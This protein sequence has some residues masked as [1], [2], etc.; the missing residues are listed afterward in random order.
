MWK[1]SGHWEERGNL[2]ADGYVMARFN[3]AGA[4]RIDNVRIITH[5]ENVAE[6]NRVYPGSYREP[7]DRR[8]SGEPGADVPF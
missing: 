3:D 2:S 8:P 6:R 1:K 5:A 4:Y 7:R